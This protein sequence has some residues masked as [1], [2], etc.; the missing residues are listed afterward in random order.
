MLNRQV[1]S[2]RTGVNAGVPQGSILGPFLIFFLVYINDLADRLSLNAK[3]F[4]DDTSLFLVIHDVDT[5]V[6]KLNNDLYQ[7]NKWA[8]QWKI[9]LTQTQPNRSKKL[10]LVKKLRK[11]IILR[12]VLTRV[13]SRKRY[14]KN[15]LAYFLMLN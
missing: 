10:V 13:L 1:S 5:S 14:T 9:A 8:F 15:S 7:I 2:W 11:F 12:Y 6:N 4:A 3:Y